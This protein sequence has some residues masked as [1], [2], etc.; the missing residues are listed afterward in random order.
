LKRSFT[1]LQLV[2]TVCVIGISLIFYGIH[3]YILNQFFETTSLL[4]P[5]WNVYVFH[6]VTL[7]VLFTLCNYQ[8]SM[9]QK[10]IFGWFMVGTLIKMVLALVFLLPLFLKKSDTKTLEALNFFIPYF[11]FL[12]FEIFSITTFLLRKV[13]E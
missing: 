13:K 11:L 7:L 12:A 2:F 1:N 10:P 3:S 6:A 8:H 9:R 4:I 5:L